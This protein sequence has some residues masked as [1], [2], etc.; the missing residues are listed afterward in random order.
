[1]GYKIQRGAA[2]VE[3]ALLLVIIMT[4]AIPSVVVF[5]QRTEEFMGCDIRN[6]LMTGLTDSVDNIPEDLAGCDGSDH[7]DTLDVEDREGES[8]E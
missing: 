8:N 5:G 1:V 4:I 2:V 6:K 7:M 3:V